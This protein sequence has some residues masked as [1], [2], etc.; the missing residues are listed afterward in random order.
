MFTQ[1]A[2]DRAGLIWPGESD[3][4]LQENINLRW[5]T[6]ELSLVIV[7][8]II[9]CYSR[10]R[11]SNVRSLA[12]HWSCRVE[13]RGL[14]SCPVSQK[15]IQAETDG[16][17]QDEDSV[18]LQQLRMTSFLSHHPNLIR[19]LNISYWRSQSSPALG[20]REQA[21]SLLPG[22]ALPSDW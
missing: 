11:W 1:L 6:G 19:L 5:P 15:I 2:A 7:T 12:S 16:I 17:S 18:I 10:S 14:A 3:G 8:K 20:S 21:P 13:W 22:R 4:S 9:G